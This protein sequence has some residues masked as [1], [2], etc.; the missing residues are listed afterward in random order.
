MIHFM[1]DCVTCG[2]CVGIGA[3]G[4]VGPL[5]TNK[6]SILNDSE[7]KFETKELRH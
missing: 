3:G 2:P 7:Y 5:L 6:V 4:F 1:I